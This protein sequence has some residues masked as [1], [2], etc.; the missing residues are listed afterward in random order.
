MLHRQKHQRTFAAAHRD[1]RMHIPAE[2][3]NPPDGQLHPARLGCRAGGE[4]DH[5]GLFRIGRRQF[6]N[7]FLA[8]GKRLAGAAQKFVRPER[9]EAAKRQ[10]RKQLMN[11]ERLFFIQRGIPQRFRPDALQPRRR[12]FGRKIYV[13]R[14]DADPGK[15][16]GRMGGYPFVGILPHE[17]DDR[18][19]RISADD[20]RHRGDVIREPPP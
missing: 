9:S 8:A 4:H 10:I 18:A 1:P 7:P 15:Q 14:N 19:R 17:P 11:L 3:F 6:E 20:P 2:A 5:R 16:T 13:H 12:L